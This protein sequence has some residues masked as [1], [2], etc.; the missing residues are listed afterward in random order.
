M[1]FAEVP[2]LKLVSVMDHTPG[3]GQ[4]ADLSR[5]RTNLRKYGKTPEEI[6]AM[7]HYRL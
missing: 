6:E 1:E 7:L 2:L 3:Q 4:Y 5:W